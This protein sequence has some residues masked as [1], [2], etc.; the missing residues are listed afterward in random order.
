MDKLIARHRCGSCFPKLKQDNSRRKK[1]SQN[2]SPHLQQSLP[3]YELRL[4]PLGW[5]PLIASTMSNFYDPLL[6]FLSDAIISGLLIQCCKYEHVLLICN[7]LQGLSWWL[8]ACK[9]WL[10]PPNMELK[11]KA[12][13]WL[14]EAVSYTLF[15]L[16]EKDRDLVWQCVD[17]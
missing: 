3:S 11:A 12:N 2:T 14:P 9:D 8:R 6:L 17:F 16:L 7:Q 15:V 13:F 10:N 1:T 4:F 5:M